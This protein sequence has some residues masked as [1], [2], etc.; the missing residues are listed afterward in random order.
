MA[1]HRVVKPV[2][3]LVLR[4]VHRADLG[5]VRTLGLPLVVDGR[6]HLGD[7]GFTL[8]P[9]LPRPAGDLSLE[10]FDGFI[11]EEYHFRRRLRMRR[12]IERDPLLVF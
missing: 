9:E 11:L 6:P 7:L 3:D 10:L 4:P 12:R 5:R 8:G 1:L 2:D